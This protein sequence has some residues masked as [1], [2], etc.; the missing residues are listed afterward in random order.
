VK[1]GR[2]PRGVHSTAR[3]SLAFFGNDDASRFARGARDR[4]LE[5]QAVR[6]LRSL[7]GVRA[8]ARAGLGGPRRRGRRSVK[9]RRQLRLK[10]CRGHLARGRLEI[11]GSQAGGFISNNFIARNGT[12]IATNDA[13]GV[14]SDNNGC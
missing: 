5:V 3:L 9:H 2:H 6:V 1:W 7:L 12:G 8:N 10:G 14:I 13:F 11:G 4:R